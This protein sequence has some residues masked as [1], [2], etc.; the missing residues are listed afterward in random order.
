MFLSMVATLRDGT[1]TCTVPCEGY[2]I[3]MLY[4]SGL[5][6]VKPLCNL[7]ERF[8][9]MQVNILHCGKF[10]MQKVPWYPAGG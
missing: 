9:V 8:T 2:A 10:Q 5:V 4:N 1:S 3:Y 7:R 6:L